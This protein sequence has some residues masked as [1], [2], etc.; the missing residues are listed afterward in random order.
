M[1]LAAALPRGVFLLV[2]GVL[3][4]R[5][6]P[7]ALMLW[8]NVVRAM[9]TTTIAALVLGTRIEIWHLV[10]AGAL[11]GTVDAVFFPAISTIVARLVPADQL[12]PANAVLQGTQQLMGTVG[13]AFAG[14][15]IAI[16][17]VG[18]AFA[19]DAASF[20][21][22]ATA[23]WLVRNRSRVAGFGDDHG[24]RIGAGRRE[25]GDAGSSSARSSPR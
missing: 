10:V 17:G 21:V 11:F 20:A 25:R 14:F 24:R 3:S 19:I 4:D 23:V 9:V 16:I 13:P 5:F 18:A 8:S 22:A 15:T 2:G 1:L 12:A 6:S 7:R